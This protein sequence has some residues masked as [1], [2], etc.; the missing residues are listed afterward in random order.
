[1]QDVDHKPGSWLRAPVLYQ[2][3]QVRLKDNDDG[4]NAVKDEVDHKA[5]K[6]PAGARAHP[7]QNNAEQGD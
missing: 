4:L 1:M 7:G 3:A 5:G 2:A 6:Q